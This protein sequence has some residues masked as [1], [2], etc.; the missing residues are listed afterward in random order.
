MRLSLAVT[1]VAWMPAREA[2]AQTATPAAP[3]SGPAPLAERLTG[4]AREDYETGRLLLSHHDEVGAMVRFRRAYRQTPDP[5][6]L[7]NM[8]LCEK[9]MQHYGRAA[10]LFQRAL[11]EGGALFTAGQA[12]QIR[13]LIAECLP[14]TG[15]LRVTVDVPGALVR[16]DDEPA[17]RAPLPADVR[18]DRGN[19]RVDVTSSGYRPFVREVPIV[20]D[21]PVT[22]DAHLESLVAEGIV[23]VRAPPD[24]DVAIDGH[25]VG[26]GA[27]QGRV[28]AGS[29]ALRVTADGMAPYERKLDV[30]A[31]QTS[32]VDVTLHRDRGLPVWLWIAGGAVAVVAVVVASASTFHSSDHAAAGDAP[33]TTVLRLSW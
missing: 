12:A 18:V 29:H 22:I 16:I 6:L 13:G 31:D 27:W 21:A 2:F 20:D 24:A 4:D 32:A 3:P 5:R 15:L 19:H 25:I 28:A 9:G 14:R 8:A 11:D 23:V 7:A 33:S 30:T 26:R 10:T 1:L 17:G